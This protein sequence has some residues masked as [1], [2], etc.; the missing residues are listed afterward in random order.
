MFFNNRNDVIETA[1]DITD[2]LGVHV[3][4]ENGQSVATFKVLLDPAKDWQA[5]KEFLFHFTNGINHKT[6]GPV[7]VSESPAALPSAPVSAETVE[8]PAVPA[9]ASTAEVVSASDETVK[10]PS[11]TPPSK[12][13]K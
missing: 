13:E 11:V 8:A 9:T 3:G 12:G 7:A 6:I 2:V 4:Q 10:T 5:V 1:E